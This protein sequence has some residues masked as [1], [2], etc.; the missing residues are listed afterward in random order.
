[1]GC[2]E[3]RSTTVPDKVA[4]GPGAV[5]ALGA[6]DMLGRLVSHALEDTVSKQPTTTGINIQRDFTVRIWT[7]QPSWTRFHLFNRHFRSGGRISAASYTRYAAPL[8]SLWVDARV[9]LPLTNVVQGMRRTAHGDRR[10]ATC[11]GVI[12]SSRA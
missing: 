7:V 8:G 6:P 12:E 11:A 4:V 9:V 1:M 10:D 2:P 3:K 5:G